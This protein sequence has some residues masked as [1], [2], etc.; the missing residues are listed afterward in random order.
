[1]YK[2][3]LQMYDITENELLSIF[4]RTEKIYHLT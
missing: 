3:H 1:M 4:K 2:I